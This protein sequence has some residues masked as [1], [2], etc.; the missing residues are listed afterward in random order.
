MGGTIA[1]FGQDTPAAVTFG[2]GG[3]AE[4]RR[5]IGN[6]IGDKGTRRRHI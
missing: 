1:N 3:R 4:H 6:T 5:S 2:A